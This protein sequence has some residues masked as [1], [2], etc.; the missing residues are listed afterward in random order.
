MVRAKEYLCQ[1]RYAEKERIVQLTAH[2][3][4]DDRPRPR[5]T[6]PAP[7]CPQGASLLYTSFCA[8]H[9]I[10]QLTG[11]IALMMPARGITTIYVL[12]RFTHYSSVDRLDRTFYILNNPRL[13]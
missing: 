1:A 5:M 11:L 10:V 3:P 9:I 8:L 13:R 6:V 7:G 4:Q 12:L 2:R